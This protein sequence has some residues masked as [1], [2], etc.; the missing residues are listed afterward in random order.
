MVRNPVGDKWLAELVGEWASS[1]IGRVAHCPVLGMSG[2]QGIG[3]TTALSK[4]VQSNTLRVAILSLDDFYLT[5]SEREKLGKTI[6][7]MCATRGAPGTHDVALMV[8]TIEALSAA[9]AGDETHW[10]TFY[11]I[12]DD[13]LPQEAERVFVGRPDAILIEGWM[14]GALADPRAAQSLPINSLEAKEDADGVWRSWQEQALTQAYMPLWDRMDAFLHL[15]APDFDT[16]MGWRCEQEE[17]T[18]GLPKGTLS[19]DRRAWVERFIQHYERI[20]RRMLSG[21][22]VEGDT[23]RVDEHRRPTAI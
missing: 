20:T 6:H 12:S 11:K 18:L 21:Y 16:V 22:R 4:V 9:G 3:K 15:L 17:T 2:A 10:P 1:A 5:K 14:V 8:Q 13:R 19:A 23:I 7:P